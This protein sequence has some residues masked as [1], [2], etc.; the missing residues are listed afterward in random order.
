SG[1]QAPG[2]RSDEPKIEPKHEGARVGSW[3]YWLPSTLTATKMVAHFDNEAAA[4]AFAKTGG[5]PAA[6]YLESAYY[7]V[8]DMSVD[9]VMAFAYENCRSTRQH[10]WS[11]VK[12]NPD[13]R[14]VVTIDAMVLRPSQYMDKDAVE[15]NMSAAEM[16]APGAADP[17]VGYTAAHG[18]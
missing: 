5:K 12:C 18:A 14:A 4:L 3:G 2:S 6:I 11:T 17:F 9:S 10:D 8:Y 16:L 13:V 7:L 1:Q 15:N